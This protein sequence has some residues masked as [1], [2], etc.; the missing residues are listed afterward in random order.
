MALVGCWVS[1]VIHFYYNGGRTGLPHTFK[2]KQEI[3]M[4]S[5]PRRRSLDDLDVYTLRSVRNR[6]VRYNLTPELCTLLFFPH[7]LMLEISV[8]FL[9]ETP[10]PSD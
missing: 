7:H 6:G 10:L 3:Y 4:V 1:D 8:G 2:T 5:I 9:Q